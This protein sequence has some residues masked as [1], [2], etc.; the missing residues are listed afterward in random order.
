MKNHRFFHTFGALLRPNIY[1][2]RF[3]T[4]L[5]TT[6][7][8]SG[9]F[10]H[11]PGFSGLGPFP[12]FFLRFSRFFARFSAFSCIFPG[13]QGFLGILGHARS[14]RA[15]W[16]VLGGWLVWGLW[17]VFGGRGEGE[18]LGLEWGG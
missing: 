17:L 5:K 7:R 15:A 14:E 10:P 2:K 18:G 13:F 9:L 6:L 11:F 8:G 16:L 1:Q 3:G 12:A 4:H